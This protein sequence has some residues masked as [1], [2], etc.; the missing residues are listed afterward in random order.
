MAN[1]IQLDLPSIESNY[2]GFA[3]LVR[4]AEQLADMS[5]VQVTIDMKSA[6]CFDA[7]MCAPLGAILYQA[8]RRFN[9]IS[10]ANILDQV[11][12]ILSKNGFLSNYGRVRRQDTYKTTI[13]YNR[14][15]PK[16]DRYFG[17]YIEK[18]FKFQAIPKMSPGLRKKFW[19]SIFEIFSYPFIYFIFRDSDRGCLLKGPTMNEPITLYL[20][21]IVG[22]NLCVASEDGQKVF[23]QIA[24][25]LRD[26]QKVRLSFLNVESLTSAFLNAA[27]GQLYGIF[28]E[29]QLSASLS[30]ADIEPD[31][32]V[33]LKRVIATAKQ[34]FNSPKVIEAA[35][36]EVLGDDDQE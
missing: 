5:Y 4:L 15:E 9:T 19:E 28:P 10:F 27:V 34:Y 18:H 6:R 13:Q 20:Y 14:F 11:E 33:L 21:E 17:A 3:N 1:R 29:G 25:A 7:N 35:R 26:K 23:E 31:D 2:K 30:A 32:L 22:S 24:T 36:Q 12:A 16:D 8:S